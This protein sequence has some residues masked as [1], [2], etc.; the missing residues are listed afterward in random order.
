MLADQR[1]VR[2]LKAGAKTRKPIPAFKRV[3]QQLIFRMIFQT[4][5][6]AK[7]V[8]GPRVVVPPTNP[9]RMPALITSRHMTRFGVME[10]LLKGRLLDDQLLS[11]LQRLTP[12]RRNQKIRRR[13]I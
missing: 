9:R 12:D 7:W 13:W 1:R 4:R 2:T 5:E 10:N 11:D 6:P 3:A 8:L